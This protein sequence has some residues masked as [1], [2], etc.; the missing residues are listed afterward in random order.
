[1]IDEVQNYLRLP[2]GIGDMLAQARGL[3]VSLTVAH[4]HLGQL[5]PTL[6]AAFQANAR[7][8]IAFRPSSDDRESLARALGGKLKP[9]DLEAL[10]AFEAYARLLV[11][12]AMSPPLLVKTPPLKAGLSDADALRQLSRQRYGVD[13]DELDAALQRRWHGPT[14]KPSGSIGVRRRRAA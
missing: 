5:T 8:K 7:S 13:G 2:V 11:R 1:V 3:G 4:Q 9:A 14:D 6:R 12:S 10:G